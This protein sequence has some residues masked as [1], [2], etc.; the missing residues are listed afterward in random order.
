MP[1]QIDPLKKIRY[2]QARLE[3]KDKKNSMIE[4]GYSPNTAIHASQEEVVKSSEKE[5]MAEIKASDIS[6]EW[7]VKQLTKELVAP[8]AKAS[9]RIR[10]SELLGKYISMFNDSKPLQVQFN[11]NDTIE[12]LRQPTLETIPIDV[13]SCSA[14]G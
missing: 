5:L 7:V 11:I 2:K 12:R 8:D 13:S 10:V 9:D 1:K 3:G 4:A 6:V 14:S